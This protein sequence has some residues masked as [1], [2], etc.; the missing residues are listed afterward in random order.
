MYW[1]QMGNVQKLE[2]RYRKRRFYKSSIEM[3]HE[4]NKNNKN[5]K[6]AGCIQRAKKYEWVEVIAVS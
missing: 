2:S 4:N 6:V 1:E 3:I 5:V